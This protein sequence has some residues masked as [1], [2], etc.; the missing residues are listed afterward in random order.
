MELFSHFKTEF[1]KSSLS[2]YAVLKCFDEQSPKVVVGV[3]LNVPFPTMDTKGQIITTNKDFNPQKV[4]KLPRYK[5]SNDEILAFEGSVEGLGSVT[6]TI[7]ASSDPKFADFQKIEDKGMINQKILV[8]TTF[9]GNKK[10]S[11]YG[12]YR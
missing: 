5:N 8:I 2:D 6:Q 12:F 1:W 10:E 11:K 7:P 3:G 4:K 9:V